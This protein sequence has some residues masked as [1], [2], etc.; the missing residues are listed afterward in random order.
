MAETGRLALKAAAL[1]HSEKQAL[2]AFVNQLQ[3]TYTRQI[4][5]IALFGSKARGDSDAD[6]DVDVL[7]IVKQ[8]DRPL[9]R[10]IIDMASDLSLEYDILLSPRV[11][12]EQ[13]WT[14]RQDFSVYRNIARDALTI[15]IEP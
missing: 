7:V 8:D 3:Q 5:Q 11:I 9:R 15:S 6:S 12:S 14:T 13:R 10:E 2:Q 4:R 1:S